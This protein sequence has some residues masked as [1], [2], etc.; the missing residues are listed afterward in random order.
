MVQTL[1]RAAIKPKLPRPS[2]TALRDDGVISMY[3]PFRHPRA[4]NALPPRPAVRITL[5]PCKHCD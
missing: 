2:E 1:F 5:T 3:G 4:E